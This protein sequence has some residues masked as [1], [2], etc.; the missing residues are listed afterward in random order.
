MEMKIVTVQKT[1][2]LWNLSSV[3]TL[4]AQKSESKLETN[5]YKH[6]KKT[7]EMFLEWFLTTHMAA[8]KTRIRIFTLSLPKTRAFFQIVHNVCIPIPRR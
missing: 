2:K 3:A 6:K 7:T 1:V 5:C 4:E 8:T